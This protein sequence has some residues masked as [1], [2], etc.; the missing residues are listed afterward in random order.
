MPEVIVREETALV[1][2]L[3][4][5]TL[6]W[7]ARRRVRRAKRR[8][9]TGIVLAAVIR[10]SFRSMS[11]YRAIVLIRE[12]GRELCA[13]SSSSPLPKWAAVAPGTHRL[14]FRAFRSSSGSTVIRD[15]V[16]AEGDVLVAF[17]RPKDKRSPFDRDPPPD[18]WHIGVV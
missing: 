3:T 5:V 7:P 10:R 16:L 4:G 13:C 6:P 18:H 8:H 11:R 1:D 17:C 12:D 15:V 9:R 14:K 2:D